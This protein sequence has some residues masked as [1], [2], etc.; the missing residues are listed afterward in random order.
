MFNDVR[1]YDDIITDGVGEIRY[2]SIPHIETLTSRIG[3]TEGS[4][5]RPDT[6]QPNECIRPM[7]CPFPQPTSRKTG[8][9]QANQEHSG[10]QRVSR[11]ADAKVIGELT[12]SVRRLGSRVAQTHIAILPVE[13]NIRVSDRTSIVGTITRIQFWNLFCDW[14]RI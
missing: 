14:L 5:S 11:T 6:F 3:C 8:R 13:A 12:F 7:N 10:R 9:T 4:K 1:K 2:G